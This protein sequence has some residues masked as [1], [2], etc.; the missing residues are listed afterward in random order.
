MGQSQKQWLTGK[1]EGKTK[2]QNFKYLKNKKSFLDEIV[3]GG[4]IFHSILGEIINV[5]IFVYKNVKMAITLAGLLS[6]DEKN[7]FF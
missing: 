5:F 4:T 3:F 2:I 7:G 1:K 6:E